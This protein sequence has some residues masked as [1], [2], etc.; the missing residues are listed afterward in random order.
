MSVKRNI[1]FAIAAA[2]Y[3]IL[4]ILLSSYDLSF[5]ETMTAHASEL[6]IQLGRRIGPLPVVLI[7]AFCVHALNQ[8]SK[9]RWYV[10]VLCFLL[11]FI[12]GWIVVIPHDSPVI[13][14]CFTLLLAVLFYCL[15][16]RIPL[17]QDS[18]ETRILLMI[19]ILTPLSGTLLVQL[20]KHVW[21][22]PRYL[23][24]LQEG[25]KFQSWLTI[26]GFRNDGDLYRSFPSAHTFSAACSLM[27]VLLPEL[28]P[29]RSW[30]RTLLLLLFLTFT[31]LVAFSRIMAGK[32]FISDVMA[33]AG[34]FLF[35]FL[36]LLFR[37]ERDLAQKE[38]QN[39]AN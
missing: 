34:I 19:G 3:I 11:C 24:I 32:H 12:A 16:I 14:G 36:L 33:G 8:F 2:V 6:F 10:D 38:S 26:S 27:T 30:N 9:P 37:K 22:R 18:E 25:A 1:R 20:I 4:L 23:A 29:K 15:V 7:P 17:P 39:P 35:I 31:V 21:S 13:E 5:S 28:Y